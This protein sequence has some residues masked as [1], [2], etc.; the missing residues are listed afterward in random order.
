MAVDHA[1]FHP[2][3]IGSTSPGDTS[4]PGDKIE[5]AVRLMVVVK[6]VP[7]GLANIMDT[8]KKEENRILCSTNDKE[9]IQYFFGDRFSSAVIFEDAEYLHTFMRVNFPGQDYK[10]YKE[11]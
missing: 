5:E 6:K 10:V 11:L 1:G 2:S 8:D 9:M 3:L 7:D 4:P